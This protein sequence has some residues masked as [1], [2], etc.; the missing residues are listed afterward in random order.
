MKIFHDSKAKNAYLSE[1][2][3]MDATRQQ[4]F[5]R[6]IM[7]LFD[8]KITGDG[9]KVSDFYILESDIRAMAKKI[10]SIPLMTTA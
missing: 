3:D 10:R 8:A 2:S 6:E 5:G 9:D 4:V 1:R 7:G